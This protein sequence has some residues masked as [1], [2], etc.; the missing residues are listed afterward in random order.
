MFDLMSEQEASFLVTSLG[1]FRNRQGPGRGTPRVNVNLIRAYTATDLY[2]GMAGRE[3]LLHLIGHA[4][5][6]TLQTGNGRA[7]RATELER[8]ARGSSIKMP[9]IV[10][11]SNCKFQSATWR[12]ALKEAGVSIVIA[13]PHVV[14]PANLTAFDMAFYSA[15]LSRVRRGQS[16]AQRVEAAFRLANAYYRSLHAPGSPYAQFTLE[17]LCE[18]PWVSWRLQTLERLESWKEVVPASVEV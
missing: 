1:L 7:I 2:E 8:R 17:K 10:V 18:S 16:T 13:S 14:T 12:S 11:S 15:L 4:D 9:A 6:T 3:D 5:A